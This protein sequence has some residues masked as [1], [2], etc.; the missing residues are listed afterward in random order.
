MPRSVVLQVTCTRAHARN[1]YSRE[2]EIS[3][4]GCA[5][6]YT[7]THLRMRTSDWLGFCDM[8]R[9][10]HSVLDIITTREMYTW[11]GRAWASTILMSVSQPSFTICFNTIT[12]SP[13]TPYSSR[14]IYIAVLSRSRLCCS[15]LSLSLTV[16]LAPVN[17]D[18]TKRILGKLLN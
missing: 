7:R 8:P 1:N 5:H 16:D 17:V 15:C 9:S 11:L 14:S 4:S 3:T 13:A 10:L 18:H 6:R 12:F 2:F